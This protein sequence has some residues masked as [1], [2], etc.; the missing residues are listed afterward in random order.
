MGL[1]AILLLPG[2][3]LTIAD[4]ASFPPQ[5]DFAA[6]YLAGQALR[7]GENP[8]DMTVADRLAAAAGIREHTPYI[9][10]PLLALTI[11][12]LSV[13]PYRFAACIW[14]VLSALALILSLRLLLPVLGISRRTFLNVALLVFFLPP[15]HYTLELGQINHFLLLL[16]TASAV[17]RPAYSGVLVGTAGALKVFPMAL[18]IVFL[19]RREF[20]FAFAAMLLTAGVLT[21]AGMLAAAHAVPATDWFRHVA[22]QITAERLITPNNQSIHA[23]CLRLFKTHA[24]EALRLSE[25]LSTTVILRPLIDAPTY[26]PL[27][28]RAFAVLVMIVTV[29]VLFATRLIAGSLTRLMRFSLVLTAALIVLP[30]VWDHY[31]VLLLLPVAVLYRK[32]DRRFV[33]TGLLLSLVL[34]VMHRYWRIIL[35]TGSSLL[36][37]VGLAGVLGLWMTLLWVLRTDA[38][39]PPFDGQAGRPVHR[40]GSRQAEQ[41]RSLE[42]EARG[43]L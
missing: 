31:Y 9:Y 29:W 37:S 41:G 30:V 25:S 21:T 26:G 6:Y 3:F 22:P 42:P 13:L 27:L 36:L 35:Y 34:I 32:S 18:G 15:V 43:L 20:L 38:E 7:A 4:L 40:Q 2:V 1:L 19:M 10:P 28:A 11:E 8:F 16:L 39:N 33:R 14:F 17:T 24:F 5:I 12:P 23:V